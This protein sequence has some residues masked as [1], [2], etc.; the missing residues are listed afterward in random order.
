MS[1]QKMRFRLY[2]AECAGAGM[3]GQPQAVPERSAG[4]SVSGTLE[5]RFA[6]S[7]SPVIGKKYS[8]HNF[9]N[10]SL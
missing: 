2:R 7:V 3:E 10:N 6:L 1:A 9:I 8:S 4:M 5:R